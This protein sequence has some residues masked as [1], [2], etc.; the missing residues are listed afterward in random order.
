MCSDFIKLNKKNKEEAE[1]YLKG[2]KTAAIFSGIV[3]FFDMVFG[4][5]YRYKFLK[6]LKTLYGFD[7]EEAKKVLNINE[8][9]IKNNFDDEE[10]N[11]KL[12]NDETINNLEFKNINTSFNN[13]KEELKRN[14]SFILYNEDLEKKKENIKREE[15]ETESKIKD[16]INN[17]GKNTGS[18][19][20]AF[21]ETGGIV[22]RLAI[23]TG[24]S[25]VKVISWAALPVTL[26]PFGFWS[27]SKINSDC[28]KMITIFEKAFTPLRFDTLYN[29]IKSF[30]KAFDDLDLIGK[31]IVE[32]NK[33]K[34]ENNLK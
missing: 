29:Y 30:I 10:E 24:L 19:I 20:R 15:K 8:S 12:L 33:P 9:S 31:K 21:A 23:E 14:S 7:Y 22:A 5:L 4:Y 18:I 26:V 25:F 34:N 3:P 11:N 32:D 16:N 1:N 6:K 27:R 13:D 17:T 2:L 28:K